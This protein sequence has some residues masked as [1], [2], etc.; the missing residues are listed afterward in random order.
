[1]NLMTNSIKFHKP[2][3]APEIRITCD[4]KVPSP[5][6][7]DTREWCCIQFA[8]KGIGFDQQYSERVFNLFQRLHGRDEYSGTGIGLALCRKIVERHG[9]S[10]D[11]ESEQ[12]K[13]ATFIIR[14]PITQP[15]IEPIHL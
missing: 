5:L 1:M 14:L 2:D 7:E 9:G 6:V 10:I 11:A 13:G 8:D 12:G 15:V 4:D 3:T